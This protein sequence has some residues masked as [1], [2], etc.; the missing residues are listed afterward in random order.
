MFILRHCTLN[1]IGTCFVIGFVPEDVAVTVMLLD[2]T[3]VPGLEFPLP[4]ELV[5]LVTLVPHAD[6]QTVENI[7]HASTRIRLLPGNRFL[8][9]LFPIRMLNKPGRNAA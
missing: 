9:F 3:G 5:P 8:Y 1:A 2:P 6:H 7:R 4:L